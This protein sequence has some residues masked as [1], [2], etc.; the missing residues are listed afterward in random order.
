MIEKMNVIIKGTES[1][2]LAV[3]WNRVKSEATTIITINSGALNF[4][5]DI[6]FPLM[7]SA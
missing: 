7:V 4:F 5:K 6:D 1:N 3:M 2:P